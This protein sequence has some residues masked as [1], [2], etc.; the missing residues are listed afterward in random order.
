LTINVSSYQNRLPVV[1]RASAHIDAF[2]YRP[3]I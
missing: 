1:G 2:E 3:K